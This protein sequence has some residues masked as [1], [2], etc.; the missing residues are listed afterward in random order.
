[1]DVSRYDW[2]SLLRVTARILRYKSYVLPNRHPARVFGFIT[3]SELQE[4]ELI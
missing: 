1:M 4:A 3:S 2:T